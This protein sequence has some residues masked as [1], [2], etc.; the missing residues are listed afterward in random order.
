MQ[1]LFQI[2]LLPESTR[3]LAE[4]LES[5]NNRFFFLSTMLNNGITKT[6]LIGFQIA[7]D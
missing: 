7:K 5:S 4:T 3:G 2:L 6:S 1:K